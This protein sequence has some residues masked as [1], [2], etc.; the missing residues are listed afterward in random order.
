MITMNR[1]P[2]L[3]L[4][5]SCFLLNLVCTSDGQN[6]EPGLIEHRAS[7][8]NPTAAYRWVEILLQVAGDEVQLVGARP[9]IIS[10]QMALPLTC[11][12][13]AWAAYDDKAVGT[14]YGGKL[15]RPQA[16]RTQQNKEKAI[17]Y[18]TYRALLNIYPKS[19]DFLDEQM[20]AMKYDP[21]DTSTDASTPQGVGNKIAAAMI[22]Y[23]HHD[24]ANQYGDEP[25]CNGK[26][27][28]DYTFYEPRNPID[29]IIDPD[30]WQQIPFSD[31][32][33]GTVYPNFLTPHWY[34]VKPLIL[35][36]SD[37]FRPGP[38]PKAASPEL[39]KQV[40]QC[41]TY[42]ANL[43]LE[44][45]SI[46]EFMRDGPRSTG[47]S[48]HWLQFAQDVSRRDKQN[49]DQDVKLFFAVGTT[50]F[51][52]FISCWEAKRFYDSSRPYML[53]RYYYGDK[54]IPGYL[55]PGKGVG[56]IKGNQWTPYSPETFVTPPFPGFPSGHATVSGACSRML[57]LFTGSD[58][59]GAYYCHKAGQWTE[60]NFTA[61]QIL[62]HD[63]KPPADAPASCDVVLK[64]PTFSGTA[65]MAA[66]SRAM[67][68][69]HIPVDNDEGL[70]LGRT[71]ANYTWPK[72]QAYFNGTAP[73]P[74]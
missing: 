53:V 38:P 6:I 47:Q 26:P 31:G 36:R 7:N 14:L 59:Y 45:K 25:G 10:R 39:K 62:A 18:A 43:T 33:G 40:D 1:T 54:E 66:L 69:Y 44:Q 71:I 11:M 57:E 63:G 46:V 55:G 20:Q 17:A 30:R 70:K 42:N 15:R 27:Y 61:A 50:A 41:I 5:G 28:S 24:G 34:R 73:E 16:E 67:G 65:E 74:R 35:E 4:W 72:Y 29:K 23:R 9:T 21:A 52:A 12:Y 58:S 51:D 64:L 13:D 48:G 60:P 3:L 68:G 56:M 22:E 37:Q 19:K 8:P 32:K 49:L 2:S